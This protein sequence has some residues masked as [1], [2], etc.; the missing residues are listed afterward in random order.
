MSYLNLQLL[1]WNNLLFY[2]GIIHFWTYFFTMFSLSYTV[3]NLIDE[4][5]YCDKVAKYPHLTITNIKSYY[6]F[7][8]S[9]R[10]GINIDLIWLQFLYL[11]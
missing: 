7:I 11:Y 10:V 9:R 1:W 5:S 8:K 3:N 4:S 2:I 6:N